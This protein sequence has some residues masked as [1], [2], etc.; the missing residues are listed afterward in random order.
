[1][2]SVQWSQVL[3]DGPA[4]VSSITWE[5][6]Q[7]EH[8]EAGVVSLYLLDSFA[9][10]LTPST[11]RCS[12]EVLVMYLFINHILRTLSVVGLVLQIPVCDDFSWNAFHYAA[13]QPSEE[14][15]SFNS[16]V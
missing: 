16:A 11:S 2:G 6:A 1:M 4:L 12:A 14:C 9:H 3:G 7:S 8:A 5:V 15:V 10:T 13:A